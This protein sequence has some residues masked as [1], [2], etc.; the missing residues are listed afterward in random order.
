MADA[1]RSFWGW[2]REGAGPNDEQAEGIRKTLEARLG[3]AE[4]AVRPAPTIRCS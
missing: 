3:V 1:P 4:L 2:G